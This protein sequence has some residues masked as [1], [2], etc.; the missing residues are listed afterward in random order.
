[1]HPPSLH[2]Y[3]WRDYLLLERSSNVRHEFLNGDIFAMAGGS[4][5]HSAIAANVIVAFGS[6]LSEGPC[7]V[8]TSDL[9]I[10]IP[11][12]GLGTYPD[13]SVVCG[14]LL[15]DPDDPDTVT[16]PI[17]LVEVTSDSTE[18][19]DR[20]LKFEHYRTVETL[21]EH[22]LVSHRERRIEVFRKTPGEW[23]RSESHPGHAVRLSSSGFSLDVDEIYRGVELP[24]ATP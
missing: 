11:V 5:E 4:P 2:Q 24:G 13:V 23:E 21:M 3:S 8:Y 16:N 12:T 18:Q 7:R 22:V 10:R 1:M 15:R 20:G 6:R 14:E 9:R 19:Y 17:V